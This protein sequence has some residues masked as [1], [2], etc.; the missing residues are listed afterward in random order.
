[1]NDNDDSHA[2]TN[3]RSFEWSED[4]RQLHRQAVQCH[5]DSGPLGAKH[6]SKMNFRAAY[7]STHRQPYAHEQPLMRPARIIHARMGCH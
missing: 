1:M 2:E 6:A 4:I 7:E 5:P 3:T